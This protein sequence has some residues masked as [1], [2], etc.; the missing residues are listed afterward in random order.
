M[1]DEITGMMRL[2][3]QH[4]KLLPNLFLELIELKFDM[5]KAPN[6]LVSSRFLIYVEG[7]FKS[8]CQQAISKVGIEITSDNIV[9]LK[10]FAERRLYLHRKPNEENILK[11]VRKDN[12]VWQDVEDLHRNGNQQ[13][14]DK[15]SE[16][17]ENYANL[18]NDLCRE[19][20]DSPTLEIHYSITI[21]F[22]RNWFQ[23]AESLLENPLILYATLI[24]IIRITIHGLRIIA[25]GTVYV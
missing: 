24:I 18:R 20:K 15:N 5:I 23:F 11:L 1:I 14:I 7:T 4:H 21:K 12:F 19:H 8:R 2:F 9:D 10:I 22:R 3:E 16:N 25:F 6:T 13:W 17:S